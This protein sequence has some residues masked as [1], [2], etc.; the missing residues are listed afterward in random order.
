VIVAAG[1]YGRFMASCYNARPLIPEVMVRGDRADII[2]RRPTFEETIALEAM[3]AW[4]APAA[5]QGAA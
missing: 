5:T 1:A 2:R 4:L 3:P